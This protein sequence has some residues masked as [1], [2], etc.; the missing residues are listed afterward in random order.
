MNLSLEQKLAKFTAVTIGVLV[1]SSGLFFLGAAFTCL[2]VIILKGDVEFS[3]EGLLI[4]LGLLCIV[5]TGFYFIWIGY[6]ILILKKI[7]K[8]SLFNLSFFLTPFLLV[9]AIL[10][11]VGI[12]NWLTGQTR[13]LLAK[14]ISIGLGFVIF[15]VLYTLLLILFKWA[16]RKQQG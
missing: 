13:S 11:V 14:I 4:L 2:I 9:P 7:T 1:G 16:F 8:D 6:S 15:V 3:I 10:L 5:F 12:D